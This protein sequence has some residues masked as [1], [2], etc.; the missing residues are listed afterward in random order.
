MG[1]GGV[2]D[3]ATVP[4]PQELLDYKSS[5]FGIVAGYSIVVV[6]GII[7]LS[8]G[9]FLNDIFVLLAA[10]LMA[11]RCSA[12]QCFTQCLPAFALFAFV[13]LFFDLFALISIL[14]LNKDGQPKAG[15]FFSFDCPLYEEV[16][17]GKNQTIYFKENGTAYTVI[18]DTKVQMLLNICDWQWVMQHVAL[19]LAVVMD[20]AASFL[21]YRMAKI[22]MALRQGDGGGPFG[23]GAGFGALMGGAGGDGMAPG[24]GQPGLGGGGGNAGARD[25]GFSRFG[26]AG[27]RLG[28]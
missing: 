14:T 11:F 1:G 9:N 6:L 10:A 13:A 25:G 21:G 22:A 27:Q 4:P 3:Q 26:G 28:G 7:S 12:P 20:L 8:L 24:G 19:L 5:L 23:G 17:L 15:D 2:P 18:K 16:K